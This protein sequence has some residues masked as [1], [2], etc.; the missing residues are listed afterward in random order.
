MRSALDVRQACACL[1]SVRLT[2]YRLYR[3]H[4]GGASPYFPLLPGSP[5]WANLSFGVRIAQLTL[6]AFRRVRR[7]EKARREAWVEG[8]LRTWGSWRFPFTSTHD[9]PPPSTMS[10]CPD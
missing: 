4:R 10:L 6:T 5:G 2:A 8:R 1:A 7:R 3:G 9:R